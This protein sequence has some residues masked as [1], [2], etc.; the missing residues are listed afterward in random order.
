MAILFQFIYTALD[1]WLLQKKNECETLKFSNFPL[2]EHYAH[3]YNRTNDGAL[4]VF[5]RCIPK[6]RALS[7]IQST[8]YIEKNAD[9]EDTLVVVTPKTLEVIRK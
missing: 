2:N 1:Q 9:A 4:F 7:H 6:R 3:I 5:N 8:F